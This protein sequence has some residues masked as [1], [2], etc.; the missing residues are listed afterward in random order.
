MTGDGPAGRHKRFVAGSDEVGE[1]VDVVVAALFEVPRSSAQEALRSGAVT[2][3]G[4]AVRP[5]HRMVSGEVL[6]GVASPPREL[7]PE[8]EE[9]P[10]EIAYSDERVM[11]VV[12]PAGLVTHPAGG[13]SGGTL[14]NALLAIDDAW[15]G[16]DPM[17]P[18]IVHRLDK[19][20]SGVL[21]VARDDDAHRHLTQA[22]AAREVTRAYIALV[23]G[24]VAEDA[25][26]IDAPIG[27]H[28]RDRRKMAVVPGG[29]S[30][31]THLEVLHRK[32]RV[33]LL[34]VTLETGRTHQIRV[35]L[36]HLR[37]PVLGDPLYGGRSELSAVA[38]LGRPFLH[39]HK[40]SFPHPDDGRAVEVTA[41]LP[42]DL[43]SVLEKLQIPQPVHG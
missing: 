25:A 14:V 22:L 42:E 7:L 18:G 21:M 29:R 37:H 34:G 26:T 40:V 35:H 30:A 5:S 31:V 10:L 39:A 27:R 12:K 17:R 9:I 43:R 36:S 8:A 13:H 16:V 32:E 15:G 3:G 11:V 20:T 19:D 28:P 33:S 38:G 4:A 2:V 41:E 24:V 6:E 23:R 1:R